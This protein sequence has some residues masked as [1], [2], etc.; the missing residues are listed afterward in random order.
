M[1]RDV[2]VIAETTYQRALGVGFSDTPE[3]RG[4]TELAAANGW[5]Q[6]YVLYL[7][8]KPAAFWMGTRYRNRFFSNCMGYDATYAKHS[9]GMYLILMAIESLCNESGP[10][11]V[12]EI[13]FGLGDAQY[14][15]MLATHSW[16]NQ[17]LYI[18]SSRL[19]GLALNCSKT[20]TSIINSGA[21]RILRS[22]GVTDRV[23]TL[24][25]RHLAHR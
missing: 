21:K 13:D 5:L 7:A 25:R 20:L 4:R 22:L 1:F 8:D 19:R 18:Y 15:E 12:T 2:N 6:T 11:R 3:M 17:S 24:W 10:N 16:T 9:P 14:K 23:K